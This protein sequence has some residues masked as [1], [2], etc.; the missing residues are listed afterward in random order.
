MRLTVSEIAS[1]A[2]GEVIA[3]DPA[4]TVSSW[5]F[6]SRALAP[7]SCFV[8]LKDHRDGHDF[9]ADAFRSGA[10]LALV[11]RPVPVPARPDRALILV[12]DVIDALQRVARAVR[13]AR[14]DLVVIG[15]TGSTGK[16]S[17]KDLLAAALPPGSVYASPES[18]NNE[19]GLP[20]TLLNA[21]AH[22]GT[23]VTEM[24]ERFPGD[25]ALL[26]D[27]ARPQHG[28][29]TNVGLAHAEHLGGPQGVAE[30]LS[31]LVTAV[32]RTGSV[33]LNADD[34][35]TP[36]LAERSEAEV[37]TVGT[38]ASADHLVRDIEIDDALHASFTL[39]GTR[40][41][42]GLRGQHQVHNAAIAAVTAERAC[43]VAF[44]ESAE[45]I[46]QA[47]GSRWRMEFL[48]GNDGVVVLNDAYNANPTS[49]EAAVRALAQ[50][51]VTGKRIA[52]LGDMRELGDHSVA[53]HEA[54]GSVVS[55]LG[56]DVLVGV[57]RGGAEIG[58]AAEIAG[59]ECRWG[60][61][62]GVAVHIAADAEEA[63]L[64][65]ERLLEP[66][67]AVLVKAS[68]AMGLQAVAA[69]LTHGEAIG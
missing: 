4:T 21:P 54:I 31:E 49:M 30:V 45:R 8:A 48:E 46:A 55:E 7:G 60:T 56:V 61:G 36:W 62:G 20:V 27:I 11:E 28:V 53:A 67:D 58:R 25:V 40:F 23:V 65:V 63:A 6:D 33:V 42:V 14:S 13:A 39:A 38:D 37:V 3:G 64:V 15:V 2:G 24:G 10:H 68:R 43:G 19:F 52:V 18:Y 9:V 34:A 16:T 69:R 41:T 12:P 66:G 29:V 50:L 44:G 35:W 51:P 57:G 47:R 5:A 26:C 32:P 1:H 22:A 17:T 59:G